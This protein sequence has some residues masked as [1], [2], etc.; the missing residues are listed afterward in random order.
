MMTLGEQMEVV[1]RHQVSPP[2]QTVPIANELGLCV[3][4]ADLGRRTNNLSG[5]IKRESDGKFNIYVNRNHHVHRRRFTIAHEIAHFILH[6]DEIGDGVTD[7]ALYR[8]GLTSVIESQ[9]NS[10]ASDILMPW[11]LMDIELRKGVADIAT[12]ANIFQVSKSSMS[13][14]M[15]VP[16]ETT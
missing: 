5:L 15:G 2:V 10:L 8:S 14:R 7:D 1:R 9:A 12:L 3:Y 16:Y 6:K 13:I 11:D 4:R